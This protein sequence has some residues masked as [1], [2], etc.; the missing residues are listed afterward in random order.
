M[1]SEGT[2]KKR[3]RGLPAATLAVAFTMAAG[4]SAQADAPSTVDAAVAAAGHRIEVLATGS[5]I[6]GANGMQVGPDGRLYVASV[7]GSELLVLDTADG[8]VVRRFTHADGVEGPDDVAFAPDGS[9][10]W[11]SI[12]SGEVAGFRPDGT[13]VVAARIGPGV[14]PLTFSPSGRLFVAQC[15][16]GTGLFEVDPDGVE[17]PRVIRDDLGPRCGLNGMD[18]GPDGRLYGPRWFRGEVVSID[19]DTGEMRTELTGVQVPAAVKFD[20]T[21]R[22]HVLDTLAGQVLRVKGGAGGAVRTVSQD[23]EV[24]ARF[25]PGLDNF[26]F[27]SADTLYVSSFVDGFVAR[28]NADGTQTMLSPAGMSSPGG[29]AV[30]ITAEGV[31]A[32]VAD[33][34]ALRGFDASS[35]KV[36]FTEANVLGVSPMGTALNVSIDGEH[37]VLASWVDN[38]VRVW[39]QR[40]QRVVERHEG[41]QEPVAAVRFGGGLAIAEHK[42]GR[43]ILMQAD[44]QFRVLAS[45]LAAPTGLVVRGDDLYL[46][47]RSQGM[48]LRLVTDGAPL[49]RPE[50]VIDG[51]AAPEGV[52]LYRDGFAIVE[53]GTGAVTVVDGEGRRTTVATLP[54][55]LPAGSAAQPPSFVFNGIASMGDGALIVTDERSRALLRIVPVSP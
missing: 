31:E 7:V 11:T 33:L 4:M 27:D 49:A 54:V 17:P 5:R 34:Q 20:S 18:W 26:A 51:L 8:R 1:R 41:L 9:V 38:D 44:G 48:L 39:S 46:T 21:G 45:G 40:E 15:F 37:L 35:G 22:L 24:V 19:V 30:R 43:V 12:L 16:F 50:T 32:V 10:Y 28:V 2:G 25:P 47:E 52:A 13:R 14:N 29:V 23:A 53:A 42:A 36:H 3:A 6:S 55:G